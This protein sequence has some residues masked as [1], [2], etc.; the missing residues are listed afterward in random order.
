MTVKSDTNL[1]ESAWCSGSNSAVAV[2][3]ILQNTTCV[4][5]AE[6]PCLWLRNSLRKVLKAGRDSKHDLSSV[7]QCKATERVEEAALDKLLPRYKEV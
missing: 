3:A 2:A 6:T 7:V 1:T 5:T 4:G